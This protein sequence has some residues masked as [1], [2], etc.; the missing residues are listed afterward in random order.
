[1]TPDTPPRY[2]YRAWADSFPDLPRPDA[3]PWVEE[4]YLIAQGLASRNVKLTADALEIKELVQDREGLQL[5]RPAARLA[6]P[7]PAATL[8]RELM[9]LLQ[10][11]QPLRR[12]RY[13]PAEILE[14]VADARRNVLAVPLR[15]RRRLFAAAGGCR[16]E[17]A[18]IE[19]G[20]GKRATTAAAEHADPARLMEA[21]AGL[22]LDRFPNLSYPTALARLRAGR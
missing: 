10:I 6:Y 11:G 2:E 16:A 8:E 19:T 20:D 22:G 9:V 1:M 13:G 4:T 15:K 18:E 14:D 17:T 5:W 21:M 3:E 12:E 7:I